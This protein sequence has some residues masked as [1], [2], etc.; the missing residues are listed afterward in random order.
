MENQSLNENV[1]GKVTLLELLDY[2]NFA[3]ERI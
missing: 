1:K 3:E 2:I